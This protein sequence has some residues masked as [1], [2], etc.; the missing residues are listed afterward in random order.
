VENAAKGMLGR[1]RQI[2]G[3]VQE[4]VYGRRQGAAS[5][6]AQ[7]NDKLE[8]A[9][10]ILN[11]ILQASEHFPTQAVACNADH[12]KIV[13]PLIE[14]ELYR[15]AGIR[16]AENSR[17]GPLLWHRARARCEAQ[18]A[19]IDRDDLLYAI[20]FLVLVEKLG[21]ASITLLQP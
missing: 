3:W 7:C 4:H 11:R 9:A 19:Q 18:V 14:T 10:Q 2:V 21:E 15:N 5:A 17:E 6:V 13:P 20:R 12:T 8:A 1:E 16:A